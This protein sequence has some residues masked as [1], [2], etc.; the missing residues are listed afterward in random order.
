M[1]CAVT[2]FCNN[3]NCSNG[4]ICRNV[5]AGYEC[6]CV[7]EWAGNFEFGG[8]LA[9]SANGDVSDFQDSDA[10]ANAHKIH[11]KMVARALSDQMQA[12]T[13]AHARLATLDHTVKQVAQIQASPKIYANC[14]Q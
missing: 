9:T 3:H 4:G 12:T 8:L 7:G 6:Q 1:P 5:E 13:A 11:V 10:S 14:V 2:N